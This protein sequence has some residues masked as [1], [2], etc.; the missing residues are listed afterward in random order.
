MNDGPI[1]ISLN[2]ALTWDRCNFLWKLKYVDKW[3]KT[4]RG[5]RLELGNMGHAMLFDLYRTGQDHSVDFANVWMTDLGG[6]DGEQ[7][8]NVATAVGQF[9]LY[10]EE[11][12]PVADRGLTTVELEYH[13][14]VKLETPQGRPFILEGYIDRMSRDERGLLWVEDYKWTGRFWSS[15]ELQ[16]DPQLPLYAAALRAL[17]IPVH[18]CMVTQV[19]TYPYKD[20]SKKKIEELFVRERF[21]VEPGQTDHMLHEYGLM[22]D[23]MIDTYYEGAEELRRSLRRDCK[24]CEMQ[25]PCLMGLKGISPISFM[26]MSDGYRPKAPRPVDRQDGV[27]QPLATRTRIPDVSV[28]GQ[29]IIIGY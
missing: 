21:A 11:F 23:E 7:I 22:V 20:R 14:E 8:Q 4:R 2:Q 25:E 18:G 15:I 16:M 3:E 28:D 9:K 24:S 1:K 12:S 27:P 6:L 13:F 26:A 19:N 17:G 5:H 10:R 29:E